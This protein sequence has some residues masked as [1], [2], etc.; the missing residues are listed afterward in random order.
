MRFRTAWHSDD[1]YG[2]VFLMLIVDIVLLIT[3]PSTDWARALQVPFVAVTLVLALRTSVA[4]RRILRAGEIGAIVAVALGIAIAA[5]GSSRAGSGIYFIMA[6]LLLVTP[7]TM[8]KRLLSHEDVTARVLM[9]ALSVYLMIGLF[10]SFLFLGI[11]TMNNGIFFVQTTT[12]KPTDFVYFSYVTMLTIGYG[13]LTP[14]TN[15]GRMLAVMDGLLGQVFLVTAV[16]RMVSM[17]GRSP[18]RPPPATPNG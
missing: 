3:M 13:D 6:A 2:W 4:P 16:A 5:F 11:A 9:G 12:V 8:F 7:P 1:A 15:M 17:F 14:L 10:F 18:R